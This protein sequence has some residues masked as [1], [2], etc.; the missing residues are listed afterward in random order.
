[1]RTTTWLSSLA[2]PAV[3]AALAEPASAQRL[4]A[5]M[6]GGPGFFEHQPP[7]L[8]LPIA[9]P[10]IVG[11]PQLPPMAALPFPAGDSGFDNATGLHWVTNGA[12]I[13]T[14]PTPTFPALGP[15][16]PPCRSRRRCSPR[17][18]AARSPGW[19]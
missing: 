6:A 19:P 18:A 16:I 9:V 14:Q 4:A 11:Y 1:M 10:P 17:S 8:E 2:L 5:F 12:L 15:V 3:A 7:T 13:A